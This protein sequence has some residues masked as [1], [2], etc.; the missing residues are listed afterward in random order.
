MKKRLAV[1][2]F[3]FSILICCMNRE[4][5][6]SYPTPKSTAAKPTSLWQNWQIQKG[7][8]GPLKIGTRIRDYKEV[9][10][11][12]DSISVDAFLYKYDGGGVAYKYSYKQTPLFVLMPAIDTDSIIAI[13]ALHSD[14][15]TV[16]GT[17]P[18]SSALEIINRQK[19]LP[20]NLD[21]LS[22]GETMRDTVNGINYIFNTPDEAH[23]AEYSDI[24]E[25][26]LLKEGKTKCNWIEI[27]KKQ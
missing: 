7:A 18:G 11:G 22:G 26:G 24:D 21:L 6:G 25:P 14:F 20:I 17:Y 10:K 12:F 15:K 23:M 4:K 27:N 16:Y 1:T 9:L 8:L 13:M 19:K 5:P 3:A 2:I